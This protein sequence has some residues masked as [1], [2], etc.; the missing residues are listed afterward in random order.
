MFGL[1]SD[2][3]GPARREAVW[4]GE[5]TATQARLGKVMSGP[6]NSGPER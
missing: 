1:G 3:N 2:G 4:H 5:G 6:A